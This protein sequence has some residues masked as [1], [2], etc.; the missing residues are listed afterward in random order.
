MSAKR[1]ASVGVFS[2]AMSVFLKCAWAAST[3]LPAFDPY[4]YIKHDGVPR[5]RRELT[6]ELAP[7]S[8][9]DCGLRPFGERETFKLTAAYRTH[10]SKC[11]RPCL[12]PRQLGAAIRH[13]DRQTNQRGRSRGDLGRLIG[14]PDGKP[15]LMLASWTGVDANSCVSTRRKFVDACNF[16]RFAALAFGQFG[17]ARRQ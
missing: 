12:L 2:F 14:S 8:A 11:G 5:A 15:H 17:T 9:G 10:R 4:A 16:H 3:P 7:A 1:S 13:L 6:G